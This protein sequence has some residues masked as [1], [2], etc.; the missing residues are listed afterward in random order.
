MARCEESY[1]LAAFGEERLE[2]GGAVGGQNA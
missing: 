1:R 2:D